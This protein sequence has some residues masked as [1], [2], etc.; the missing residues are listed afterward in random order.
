LV[1]HFYS[2]AFDWSCIVSRPY[3]IF[4]T[5]NFRRRSRQRQLSATAWGLEFNDAV[6]NSILYKYELRLDLGMENALKASFYKRE[7]MF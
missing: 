6:K 2:S 5:D 3:V 7:K 1:R 4:S